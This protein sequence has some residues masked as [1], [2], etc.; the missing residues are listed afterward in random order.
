[1]QSIQFVLPAVATVALGT[2]LLV[3]LRD[4]RRGRRATLNNPGSMPMSPDFRAVS[5]QPP[6]LPDASECNE[7]VSEDRGESEPARATRNLSTTL[8]VVRRLLQLARRTPGLELPSDTPLHPQAATD[9]EDDIVLARSFA[10]ELATLL[11]ACAA[12]PPPAPL[13]PVTPDVP[14]VALALEVKGETNDPP[15][16][17]PSASE[18]D[19]APIVIS[20]PRPGYE[21]RAP[22]TRLPLRP[23]R[24]HIGWPA[25]LDPP[26]LA[27]DS[28]ARHALLAVLARNPVPSAEPALVAAYREEDAEGRLLVLRSLLSG[29]FTQAL[30][31]FNEAL[32][33]GTDDERALAIDALL[34][35]G[36]REALT[37]AFADRVEAISAQAA[38]AY[39][40]TTNRDDYRLALAP[41]VDSARIDAILA[42]LAG[43]VE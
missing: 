12:V 23:Q 38:L 37:P 14:A 33:F 10:D 22:L 29:K 41:F 43:F 28:A 25:L 4:G 18:H 9:T 13:E 2:A 32:L 6:P 27:S 8:A 24:M 26:H 21:R 36:E 5:G 42:L 39:V 19:D 17:T 20:S 15:I 30:P 35:C 7:P 16:D 3:P 34:A 31:I 11:P 1:M 40:G